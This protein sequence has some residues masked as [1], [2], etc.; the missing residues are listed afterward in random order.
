MNIVILGAGQVGRTVAT[1]LAKEQ[2]NNVTLVD[3][4]PEKLADLSEKLDIRTVIGHASHPET[5]E[6]AGADEAE[7]IIALTDSDE[8]NIV[9]CEVAHALFDNTGKKA[10]KIARIRGT[11]YYSSNLFSEDYL[12]VDLVINPEA[13]ITKYISELIKYPGAL[14]VLEF[15]EGKIR[16]VG[17]RAHHE[18]ALVGK[19]LKELSEHIPDIDSRFVTIYR[20]GEGI[21][22]DGSTIVSPGDEV[23]FIA[24]R[25]DIKSV[26]S[27]VRKLDDPIRKI[28]IAGGG[29]IGRRLAKQLENQ[30]DVKIIEKNLEQAKKLS[31]ALDSTIVLHGDAANEELLLE[32]QIEK[33][34]IFVAVTDAEEANILSSMLAKR[35]GAKKVIALINK[36]AY[37]ELLS[38]DTIDIAI[39]PLHI[40]LG[41][42]L[43]QVRKGDVVKVYSL[44]RGSAEAI[45][46]IAHGNSSTSEVVGRMIDDIKLPEGATISAILRNDEVLMAHH[47]TVIRENDHV[48]LFISKKEHIHD[49]EKLFESK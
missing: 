41:V 44:R 16:M 27:E 5:L 7:M 6:R 3:N 18:G 33:T 32:E 10:K 15:A 24:A 35:L 34:D 17:A 37:S 39:S 45:E 49:V 38:G 4:N 2:S 30:Y 43:E 14:Q 31:E 40:M 8:L 26:L 47:D 36:P 23:F 20:Q 12:S 9:A 21:I 22:P 28:V 25:K 29:N 11:E 13:I 1:S 46:A 42:V 48:I 19:P